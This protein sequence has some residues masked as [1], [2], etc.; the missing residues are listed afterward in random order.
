[1]A[2]TDTV[3]RLVSRVRRK[4]QQLSPNDKQQSEEQERQYDPPPG[5]PPNHIAYNYPPPLNPVHL[6]LVLPEHQYNLAVQGWTTISFPK[7]AAIQEEQERA[8][9]LRTSIESLFAAGKVFFDRPA[10]YKSRFLT[11]QGSEEGWNSI[12]GEKEF[13]T[14]RSLNRVPKEIREAATQ[15]WSV[16][17]G[18]LTD[19]LVKIAESL[20]L[21][22]EALA[23][24]ARPCSTIKEQQTATMLRIFR[25]E[26]WEDKV[27]AE[28]HN[29]LGL[30]SFVATDSPGL[31]VWSPMIRSFYPIEQSYDDLSSTGSLLV[32]RQLQRFSNGR[33]LPGGHRVMSYPKAEAKS[34]GAVAEKKY[35]FSVVF[36]LRAHYDEIIHIKSLSSPITGENQMV[37]DGESAKQ[38]FT[39]LRSSHYNIN[40]NLKDREKQKSHIRQKRDPETPPAEGT[41]ANGI[42]QEAAQ[43]TGQQ[44]GNFP[45]LSDT[46]VL[47]DKP[48][49]PGTG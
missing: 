14:V 16:F 31:E 47:P 9:A 13:I 41:A 11:K 12:P 24:F 39:D 34:R 19:H 4:S 1:M 5:P 21:E 20:S 3:Q 30:L 17:G 23:R 33:Y 35:R 48:L 2:V 25:Y 15:A 29:D 7:H 6:P 18:L 45:S 28:P 22:P 32:G 27:V 26:T 38:F 43:G 49:L 46:N 42:A 37:K 8:N 40:T 10:E 44:T 36:V